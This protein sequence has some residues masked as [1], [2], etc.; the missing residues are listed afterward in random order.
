MQHCVEELA[1]KVEELC[2]TMEEDRCH[3]HDNGESH[4]RFTIPLLDLEEF[5][6]H[7]V[8]GAAPLDET[9]KVESPL[10][11]R[12]ERHEEAVVEASLNIDNVE[13]AALEAVSG[14]EYNITDHV[15]SGNAEEPLS[16]YCSHTTKVAVISHHWVC[17]C[18]PVSFVISHHKV[19][20]CHG[21]IF[22]VI[23]KS[24]VITVEGS[25][26][27]SSPSLPLPLPRGH[28]FCHY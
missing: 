21:V 16:D 24:A 27:L 12:V 11:V 3:C 20:R 14:E 4:P 15:H 18:H 9:D 1:G 19:C 23:T 13:Q 22:L 2:N 8:Q 17:H 7:V 26:F 6:T 10:P 28:I 5:G 25:N